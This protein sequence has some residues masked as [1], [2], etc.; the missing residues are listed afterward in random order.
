[1]FISLVFL[2]ATENQGNKQVRAIDEHGKK[3][4]NLIMPWFENVILIL[5]VK[6]LWNS[7]TRSK[8]NQNKQKLDM[9]EAKKAKPNYRSDEE[10][11][12]L[13]NI[14]LLYKSG[15]PVIKSLDNYS[16]MVS[17]SKHKANKGTGLKI[18]S[19]K[20][21]SQRL[22]IAL[23]QVKA[24]NNSENLLDQIRQIIYSPSINQKKLLKKC[25]II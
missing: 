11:S 15:E 12:A 18:L 25:T 6:W 13:Y 1:M 9:T 21:M 19:A 17:E 8:T 20:H 7:A 23:T 5:K 10:K 24:G 3:P 4:L 14:D 2:K 22:Q 16:S